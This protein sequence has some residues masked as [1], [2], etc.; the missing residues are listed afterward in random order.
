MGIVTL[1]FQHNVGDLAIILG[2]SNFGLSYLSISVSL[3]V[4][5]TLMIVIR[6]IL[7]GRKI[8]IATGALAGISRLYK[9]ISTMFI[10]SCALFSV[11][12]LLVIGPLAA[13]MYGTTTN[14]YLIGIFTVEIFFPILAEIQVRAFPRRPSLGRL[15]NA[16]MDL[17]GDRSAAHHSTGRQRERVDRPRC[18]HWTH[19]FVQC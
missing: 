2:L 9:T 3:N 1:Y 6:L 10:E 7:H 16:M 11:T 12:S 14:V 5:L 17:I 8:R 4:L 18:Y 13:V 15:S 19:Q